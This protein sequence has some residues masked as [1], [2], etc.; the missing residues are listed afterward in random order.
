MENITI[1]INEVNK[2]LNT[3]QTPFTQDDVIWAHCRYEAACMSEYTSKDIARML[4]G[5]YTKPTLESINADIDDQCYSED[6]DT[7]Q[8]IIDMAEFIVDEIY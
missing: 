7:N 6:G 3:D 4:M 1:L 5:G 8:F 2:R